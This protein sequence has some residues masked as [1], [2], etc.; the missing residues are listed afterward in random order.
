MLEI[1]TEISTDDPKQHGIPYQSAAGV[2]GDLPHRGTYD[3]LRTIFA[4]QVQLAQR[5]YEVELKNGEPMPSEADWGNLH[6]RT[7]QMRLQ[8][9]FGYL[10]R[11]MGE[12]VQHLDAKPWKT[13]YRPTPRKEFVEE[14]ADSL[15]F[16]VEFCLVAGIGSKELFDT[17][18][19]KWQT[20]RDRQASSY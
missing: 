14:V 1:P 19:S 9:L 20:N 17:Y 13:N 10:V 2:E 11:E 3:M 6:S 12:A 18:F 7:V 5:Y 4:G 16:F 8:S 15:H